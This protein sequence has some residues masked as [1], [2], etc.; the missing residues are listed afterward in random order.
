MF[1][2]R[3]LTSNIITKTMLGVH[4][5]SLVEHQKIFP[6]IIRD[7]PLF[8]QMFGDVGGGTENY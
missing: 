8:T 1:L 5:S 7:G 6:T 4:I 3:A 2:C